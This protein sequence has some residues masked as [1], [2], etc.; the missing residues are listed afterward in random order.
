MGQTAVARK[1]AQIL[2][3]AEIETR[4]LSDVKQMMAV[5]GQVKGPALVVIHAHQLTE[6][7]A[8]CGTYQG[9]YFLACVEDIDPAV[10]QVAQDA[11]VVGVVGMPAPGGPPRP[12]EL[13]AVA[14]RYSRGQLPLPSTALSW[15]HFW[16]ERRLRSSNDRKTMV[17][18]VERF[19][20]ELQS[21]RQAQGA[22]QLADE[23][24]MN[25]I[26]DAPL[27][28]YGR[29]RYAHRRREPI[30][31]EPQEC[32]TFGFGSDGSK[33]VISVSDPFGHLSREAV[34]GGIHRGLTTGT[35][36]TSGG[37]AGL[38]MLLIH[39]TAKILFV[40]VIPRQ[41]TQ[42]TAVIE[43]DVAPDKLRRLPGS[44]YYFK[45]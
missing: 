16:H 36:D 3:C 28:Q 18:A 41:T 32:P 2:Q 30:E 24:I 1:M 35:M 23:L 26:Y 13:L 12:W 22:A 8:A 37:G 40:D 7:I 5:L 31:L 45:H 43:L 10:F 6:A 44:V 15:G 42:V 25:A 4:V 21:S 20:G 17:D 19:C 27:D 29:Q 14:N 33:I 39:N 38:G 11:R 34:F 9:A